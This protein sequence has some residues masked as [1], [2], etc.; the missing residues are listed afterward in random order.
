MDRKV[1]AHRPSPAMLVAIVALIS[2]FAGPA[3]ADQAVTIAAKVNG[4]KIKSRSISG[5]KLKNNTIT[6]KQVNEGKLGQVPSAK[7]ADSATNATN[8]TNATS[9]TNATNAT[10]ASNADKVDG[11][12]A[13]CPSG[14]QL[15]EGSC[16]ETAA[17]SSTNFFNA[18]DACTADGRRLPTAD[19]LLS[20]V[21]A[22]GFTI[23]SVEISSNLFNDGTTYRYMG[24]SNSASISVQ[25]TLNTNAYRCV[26][27]LVN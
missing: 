25:T 14:T 16:V 24:V 5:N 6:G 10:N 19:E 15:F 22:G 17:R 12:N 7:S 21:A 1:R 27:P 11:H 18:S 13:S 26:A 4:S 23:A 9:A 20:M 2:S 8:A 3:L